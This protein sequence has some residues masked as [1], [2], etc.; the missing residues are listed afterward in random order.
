MARYALKHEVKIVALVCHHWCCVNFE[1]IKRSLQNNLLFVCFSIA[2]FNAHRATWSGGALTRVQMHFYNRDAT[3]TPRELLL[4]NICD[5]AALL[6]GYNFATFQTQHMR[7]AWKVAKLYPQSYIL[8]CHT[9][10]CGCNSYTYICE[11][12]KITPLYRWHG[13][14]YMWQYYTLVW[15]VTLHPSVRV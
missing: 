1:V 2:S 4:P 7:C 9:H 8:F 15:G 10:K 13:Y 12:G 5:N 3:C 6:C 14:H 11:T